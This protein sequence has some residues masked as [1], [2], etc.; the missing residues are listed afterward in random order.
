[1]RV[2]L[3]L[4]DEDDVSRYVVWSGVSFFR[5]CDFGSLLPT[6]FDDNVEYLVLRPRGPAISIEPSA[7]DLHPLGGAMVDLF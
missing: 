6:S 3:V 1:M 7:C 5:E 2:R 4:E